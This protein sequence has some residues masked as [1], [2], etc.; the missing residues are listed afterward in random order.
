MKKARAA[1]EESPSSAGVVPPPALIAATHYT[2]PGAFRMDR[3]GLVSQQ[4]DSDRS[5]NNNNTNNDTSEVFVPHATVVPDDI[6]QAATTTVTTGPVT[7]TASGGELVHASLLNDVS[8]PEIQSKSVVVIDRKRA[9]LYIGIIAV[10]V[11]ALVVGLTLA[12][13]NADKA[14]EKNSRPYV[15]SPDGSRLQN[16]TIGVEDGDGD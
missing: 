13:W 11:I 6:E 8:Q 4:R 5:N 9:L 3:H 2:A 12:L 15:P 7:T 16:R 10:I 14:D 1:D